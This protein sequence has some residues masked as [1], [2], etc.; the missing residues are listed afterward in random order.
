MSQV[1]S[2]EEVREKIREMIFREKA[3]KRFKEWMSQ[4][5]ARAYIS[6]R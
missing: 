4:L 6:V 5:K 1:P 2:L 3:E